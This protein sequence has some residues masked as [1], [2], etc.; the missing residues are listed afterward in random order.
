ME[1]EGT[2]KEVA[3]EGTAILAR[4]REQKQA[5]KDR[6]R[7]QKEA[8]KDSER[9]QKEVAKDSE[10]EQK[11]VAKD[12]ER[13]QKEATKDREREQKEVAK[14]REREQKQATKEKEEEKQPPKEKKQKEKEDE[15]VET[16]N[17]VSELRSRRRNKTVE[18]PVKSLGIASET[19]DE[20]ATRAGGAESPQQQRPLVNTVV[21]VVHLSVLC[22]CMGH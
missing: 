19:E 16:S 4:P 10:R 15:E 5:T 22:V 1:G 12:R 8:T 7:E 2:G 9:E 20:G 3:R 17:L 14:D 11:E 18:K 6:E 13:E 21:C